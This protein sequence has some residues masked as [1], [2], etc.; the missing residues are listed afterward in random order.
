MFTINATYLLITAHILIRLFSAVAPEIRGSVEWMG[1]F[2]YLS[3]RTLDQ[4]LLAKALRLGLP[5]PHGSS[6]SR[7]SWGPQ[8]AWSYQAPRLEPPGQGLKARYH[9]PDTPGQIPQAKTDGWKGGWTD[10]RNIPCIAQDI[11]KQEQIHGKTVACD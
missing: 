8:E 11:I 1:Q 9:K 6:G 4:S 7:S 10:A 2:I 5:E 3:E